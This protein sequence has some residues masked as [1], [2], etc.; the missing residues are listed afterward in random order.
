[1]AAELDASAEDSLQ[2]LRADVPAAKDLLKRSAGALVFPKVYKAGFIVGGEIGEGALRAG[3]KTLDYYNISAASYG[4]QIGAQSMTLILLFME[5]AALDKFRAGSGW[6]VGNDM[7]VA[8]V[9]QGEAKGL[10]S[11]TFDKPVVAFVLDQ[12]GLMANMALEGTKFTKI[13]K[14]K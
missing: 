9:D 14:D 7:S 3:N 10:S 13:R 1:T 6:E 5:K 2:R 12:K 4:L 11:T 8:V